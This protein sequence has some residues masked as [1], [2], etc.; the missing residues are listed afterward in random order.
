VMAFV[1]DGKN[2]EKPY[3][4]LEKT[5]YAPMSVRTKKPE[6]NGRLDE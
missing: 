6:K 2:A 5:T 3:L 4:S 1:E